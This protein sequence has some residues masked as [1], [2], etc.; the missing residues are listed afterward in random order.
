MLETLTWIKG[1]TGAVSGL[2]AT[3]PLLGGVIYEAEH[4]AGQHVAGT[5]VTSVV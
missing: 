4:T 5:L 1:R 2:D 3:L